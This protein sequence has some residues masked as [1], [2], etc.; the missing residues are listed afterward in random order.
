M[1]LRNPFARRITQHKAVSVLFRPPESETPASANVQRTVSAPLNSAGNSIPRAVLAP[2]SL[3]DRLPWGSVA[4]ST[5]MPIE[6][7]QT[8]DAAQADLQK[9]IGRAEMPAMQPILPDAQ[10]PASGDV[11]RLEI[12]HNTPAAT[13]QRQ[14]VVQQAV[15][16][17]AEVDA[18]VQAARLAESIQRAE[19]PQPPQPEYNQKE[20]GSDPLAQDWP[21]LQTILRRHEEIST[22]TPVDSTAASTA[23][24]IRQ[25][26]ITAVPLPEVI[27]RKPIIEE[28]SSQPAAPVQPQRT[29]VSEA[30]TAPLQ[31][32]PR[33][34]LE[35][36]AAIP[37]EQNQHTFTTGGNTPQ[38]TESEPSSTPLQTAGS[39]EMPAPA[40][41]SESPDKLMFAA[42]Q[43]E[44]AEGE[45][46]HRTAINK[47]QADTEPDAGG[48]AQALPLEA[49]WPV[50]RFTAPTE[51]PAWS[52]QDAAPDVPLEMDEE[53][54]ASTQQLRS[55]LENISVEQPTESHVELVT[56]RKPRPR[57]P[58]SQPVQLQQEDAVPPDSRETTTSENP[59]SD[60]PIPQPAETPDAVQMSRQVKEISQ[61]AFSKPGQSPET[62]Q[63]ELVQTEIG[64][65]PADLW[66]LLGQTPPS[67]QQVPPGLPVPP[68][69]PVPSGAAHVRAEA[70]ADEMPAERPTLAG[71]QGFILSDAARKPA[72][73]PAPMPAIVQRQ[74]QETDSS[75]PTQR[76]EGE[77]T[78]VEGQ[79]ET[80]A[81]VD[82]DELAR[83]VYAQIKRRLAVEWERLRKRF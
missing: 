24:P 81:E 46:F 45:R 63:T 69:P 64:P 43:T 29:P 6:Q 40:Q 44:G 73:S 50:Q 71:A 28:I 21:R 18:Q 82:T 68:G 78:Q 83:K 48:I 9:I 36:K 30:Q 66:H 20:T 53:S 3:L 38:L 15:E 34:A 56:P 72:V 4:G 25:E 19:R 42:E 2:Q 57:L 55:L 10:I 62:E 74:A 49:A 79:A 51:V 31:S 22:S 67:V 70:G 33:E 61:N 59:F 52:A 39:D 41:S 77:E 23:P 11:S 75:V 37:A 26:R 27:A 80:G 65:L 60:F 16:K 47:T 8:D 58:V 76:P 5:A 14:P 13:L 17:Q 32:L 1:R 7:I 12:Q 35:E 54:F